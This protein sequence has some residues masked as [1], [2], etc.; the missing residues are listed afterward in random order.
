MNNALACQEVGDTFSPF[1][2]TCIV[3]H[4]HD[5]TLFFFASSGRAMPTSVLSFG[6]QNEKDNID[7]VSIVWLCGFSLLLSITQFIESRAHSTIERKKTSL[8][9]NHHQSQTQLI[10]DHD[11][12]ILPRLGRC[13]F[14]PCLSTNVH[15][16]SFCD[17][18]SIE[19]CRR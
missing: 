11:Y 5:E 19:Q 14:Y 8:V 6:K 4:H 18:P 1:G 7:F 16:V 17:A 12:Q 15:A 3:T 13:G 10:L 9:A 2:R